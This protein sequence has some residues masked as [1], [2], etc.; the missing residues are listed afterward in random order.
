MVVIT[1]KVV[2]GSSDRDSILLG[3]AFRQ[4]MYSGSVRSAGRGTLEKG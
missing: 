4:G 1:G 3:E 2:E